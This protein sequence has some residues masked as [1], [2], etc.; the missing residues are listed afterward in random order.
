MYFNYILYKCFQG[1]FYCIKIINNNKKKKQLLY[2][3]S[4]KNEY[5]YFAIYYHLYNTTINTSVNVLNLF[6]LHLQIFQY[7]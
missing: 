2:T 6:S 1:I 7:I 4:N 3:I 5:R